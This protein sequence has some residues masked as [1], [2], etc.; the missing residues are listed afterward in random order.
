MPPSFTVGSQLWH[1]ARLCSQFY[2][3]LLVRRLASDDVPCSA[4][5]SA[6]QQASDLA[7]L[8]GKGTEDVVGSQLS[9]C[10]GNMARLRKT[11]LNMS[12]KHEFLKYYRSRKS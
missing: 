11:S 6:G 5:M 10:L 1:F 8:A 4:T 3:T 7:A 2:N 9:L 12:D